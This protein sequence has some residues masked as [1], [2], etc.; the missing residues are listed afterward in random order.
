MQLYMQ[1]IFIDILFYYYICNNLYHFK[2]NI[3]SFYRTSSKLKTDLCFWGEVFE[4][5]GLPHVNVITVDVYREPDR[6]PRK[7]DKRFLVR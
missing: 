3:F 6:K 4:F 7:R 1:G 5:S 2:I